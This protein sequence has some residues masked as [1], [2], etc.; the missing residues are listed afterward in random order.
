MAKKLEP[1]LE[2]HYRSNSIKVLHCY[3]LSDNLYGKQHA[4]SKSTF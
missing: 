3:T 2:Q 1:H 4:V